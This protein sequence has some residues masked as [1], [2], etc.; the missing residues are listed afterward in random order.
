VKALTV[1]MW[2]RKVCFLSCSPVMLIK[3]KKLTVPLCFHL[4]KFVWFHSGGEVEQHE[5]DRIV[6]L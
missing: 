1:K 4:I 6:R 5:A 2:L 3:S